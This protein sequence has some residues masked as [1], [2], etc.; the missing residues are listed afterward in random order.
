MPPQQL[1]MD[2]TE[3]FNSRLIRTLELE[4]LSDR[5]ITGFMEL[6][7]TAPVLKPDIDKGFIVSN[8]ILNDLPVGQG[9]LYQTMTPASLEVFI[10]ISSLRGHANDKSFYVL[11]RSKESVGQVL[12]NFTQKLSQLTQK[13]WGNFYMPELISYHDLSDE[14]RCFVFTF[15]NRGE[16]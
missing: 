5:T 13:D 15:I 6:I 2:N 11:Y 3:K 10:P 1:G 14:E 4:A 16:S 7:R 8:S 9:I 12:Y